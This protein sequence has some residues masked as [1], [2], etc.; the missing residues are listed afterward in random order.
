MN[1]KKV[2]ISTFLARVL[3]LCF[4]NIYTIASAILSKPLSLPV[5]HCS[6]HNIQDDNIPSKTSQRQSV[7]RS[8]RRLPCHPGAKLRQIIC[9][10]FLPTNKCAAFLPTLRLQIGDGNSANAEQEVA[11]QWSARITF[12]KLHIMAALRLDNSCYISSARFR[13]KSM[14]LRMP[15]QIR[16]AKH[17]FVCN[18]GWVKVSDMTL[19]A[20]RRNFKSL[21]RQSFAAE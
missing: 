14:D 1:K 2:I 4:W 5:W 16:T 9:A 18:C 7:C 3:T 12:A 21:A 17:S 13:V 8:V 10:T 20:F 19:I 15:Q 6:K 11:N